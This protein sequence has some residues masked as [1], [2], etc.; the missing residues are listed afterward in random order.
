MIGN[1]ADKI[2]FSHKLLLTNT[3][4]ANLHKAFVNNS[5]VDIKLS[6]T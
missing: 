1:S 6:K 4:V 2:N 3:Q 5:S